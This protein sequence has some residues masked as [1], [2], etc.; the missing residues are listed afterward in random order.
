[1]IY[2]IFENKPENLFPL[3]INHA[4]FEVRWGHLACLIEYAI[5]SIKMIVLF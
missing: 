5:Q 3:T 2:T 4:A 1:M